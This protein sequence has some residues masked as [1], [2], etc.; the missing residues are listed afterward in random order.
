MLV[1][2]PSP[3]FKPT[4]DAARSGHCI[5]GWLDHRWA[6]HSTWHMRA[7]QVK[8]SSQG[9]GALPSLMM[10]MTQHRF[11]QTRRTPQPSGMWCPPAGAPVSN[12]CH[13]LR[14]ERLGTLCVKF[15]STAPDG[16]VRER[17]VTIHIA[18]KG[19]LPRR[20]VQ[21]QLPGPGESG[22]ASTAMNNKEPLL[23]ICILQQMTPGTGT[24]TF[25]L[26]HLHYF[27]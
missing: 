4:S 16:I 25:D 23:N 14:S 19:C 5:L 22:N 20:P 24:A 18:R 8:N 12:G 13:D 6:G 9:P 3:D 7:A 27:I 26:R 17:R 2:R 21:L 1:G 10:L 11:C 15:V